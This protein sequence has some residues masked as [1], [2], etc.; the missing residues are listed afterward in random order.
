MVEHVG[1]EVED[2][3]AEL[4][5]R[6]GD[7]GSRALES[8]LAGGAPVVGELLLRQ[9]E[10]LDGLVVEE[11]GEAVALALLRLEHG[12]GELP[13]LVREP[14]DV[15]IARGERRRHQRGGEARPREVRELAHH[16]RGRLRLPGRRV[17]RRRG[18]GRRA[19]P[20]RP[21]AP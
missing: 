21:S 10:R 17:Q 8:R 3:A 11:I 18:R 19:P 6:L 15:V 13:A 7:R 14:G 12:G 9:R 1:M 4:S 20:R 16:A 5:Q 2:L